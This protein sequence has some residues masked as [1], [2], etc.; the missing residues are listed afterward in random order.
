METIQKEQLLS[1]L[2]ERVEDHLQQAIYRFQNLT[3]QELLRPSPTGGWSIAQCLDHINSYGHY[4]L[5]KIQEGIEKNA[6]RPSKD[7]FKSS[8]LGAYFIRMMDPETGRK[9]YKAFKGHIP[10]SDLEAYAVVAKFIQQQENLLI[11]LKEAHSADLNAISIPISI[12]RFITLKLG[13]VFQFIIA[14]DE[15]HIQQALRNVA[16]VNKQVPQ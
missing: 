15:R 12:A 4:Y 16:E 13:D 8:W 14:H 11:Y 7:T 2:E 6:L 3:E 1:T 10:T 9:K 5:P